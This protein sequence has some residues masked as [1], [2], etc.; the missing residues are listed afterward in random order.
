MLIYEVT[1]L[2]RLNCLMYVPF[3]LYVHVLSAGTVLA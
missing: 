2:E 3:L 1:C